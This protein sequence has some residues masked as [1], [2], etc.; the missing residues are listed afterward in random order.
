MEFSQTNEAVSET[1]VLLSAPAFVLNNLR[2]MQR[3]AA[4]V[5]P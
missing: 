2:T 3:D 5:Q 1:R 4:S